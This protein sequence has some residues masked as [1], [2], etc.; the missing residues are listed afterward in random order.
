[1]KTLTA[2]PGLILVALSM[3]NGR[4]P[5]CAEAG[6]GKRCFS[7]WQGSVWSTAGNLRTSSGAKATRSQTRQPHL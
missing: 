1:M 6:A 2:I 3:Q 4:S 5:V 7:I